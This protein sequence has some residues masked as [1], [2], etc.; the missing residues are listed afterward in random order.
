MVRRPRLR[1][2]ISHAN[3]R[4]L[5]ANY[6]E[7]TIWCYISYNIFAPNYSIRVETEFIS[8]LID[9]YYI[10]LYIYY[11][12][13]I[14]RV[15]YLDFCE[16]WSFRVENRDFTHYLSF[17]AENLLHFSETDFFESKATFYQWLIFSSQKLRFHSRYNFSQKPKV[18]K[19]VFFQ[20]VTL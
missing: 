12:F 2:C 9:S 15:K 6:R 13:R 4:S 20:L 18:P 8:S 7:N 1:H 3:S 11:S 5:F 16:C 14:F 19:M 10:L 17:R